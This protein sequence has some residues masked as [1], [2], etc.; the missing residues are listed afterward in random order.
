MNIKEQL[1]ENL[2]SA[3]KAGLKNEVSVI[4]NIL[5]RIM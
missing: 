2:K 3:M 5:S 4:C 1:N